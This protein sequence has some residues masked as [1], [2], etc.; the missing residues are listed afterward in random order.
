MAWIFGEKKFGQYTYEHWFDHEFD[1]YIIENI[2][3]RLE[4]EKDH[5]A[6]EELTREAFWNEHCPG[7]DEHLLVHN[8]RKASEFIHELNFVA[9][10]EEKIVGNI[11]YVKTLVT[12]NENENTVIT[13]GPVSVL[14]EFQN[15][16]IG[17]LLINH[18][19]KLSREMEY[20]AIIIY[21]DPE[22][23]KK[24]GFK[25]S[26]Y[27]QITNKE[28]KYPAALLVLELYPNSLCG[29]AGKFDEGKKYETNEEELKEFEKGFNPKEKGYKKSQERFRELSN[30]YL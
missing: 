14:P 10:Y 16:G 20:K 28:D 19:I 4:E 22:Y 8:L 7:C 2:E 21:G 6:V 26:K 1:K 5:R 25:E 27:Y 12:D 9:M 17:K 29:I 13:F 3:L 30:K 11:V 15:R 24:F 18:T 23:Y